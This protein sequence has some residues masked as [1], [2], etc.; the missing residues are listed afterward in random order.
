MGKDTFRPA[1]FP[2]STQE[3]LFLFLQIVFFGIILSMLFSLVIYNK[4]I[5]YSLNDPAN[6]LTYLISMIIVAFVLFLINL[7]NHNLKYIDIQG[8]TLTVVDRAWFPRINKEVD[9][10][11]VSSLEFRRSLF[12]NGFYICWIYQMF[13]TSHSQRN[14]IQLLGWDSKTL[15]S[16][17]LSVKKSCPTLKIE[18]KT[19]LSL[20][21]TY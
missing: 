7:I 12:V 6:Y 1:L 20:L 11:K 3:R 10:T 16:F 14:K 19:R 5:G 18:N 2:V 15:E 9:L 4:N 13:I 8:S 21:G 17:L